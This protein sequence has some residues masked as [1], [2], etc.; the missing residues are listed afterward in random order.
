MTDK[1]TTPPVSSEDEPARPTELTV[2]VQSTEV[3]PL[4]AA[5]EAD[6]PADSSDADADGAGT[7]V[8][9]RDG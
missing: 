2:P 5:R 6:A 1:I 4:Q 7:P 3:P 8:T 9:R